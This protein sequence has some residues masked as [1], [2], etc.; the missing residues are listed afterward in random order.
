MAVNGANGYGRAESVLH[1]AAKQ[2]ISVVGLQET[3]RPARTIFAAAGFQVFCC[4]TETG[5]KRGVGLAVKESMCRDSA[6]T[7]EYVDAGLMAMRFE[8][9]GRRGAVNLV[10]DR[11]RHR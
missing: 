3:R 4:G 11:C 6:Y 7:T 9:K 8:M 1:E 10:A 2:D 5:G